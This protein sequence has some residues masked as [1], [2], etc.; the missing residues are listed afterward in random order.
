MTRAA[1]LTV[2]DRCAAGDRDDVSG[3]LLA[4]R[5]LALPASVVRQCVSDDIDRITAAVVDLSAGCDLLVTTGGT[6]LSARDV[7]PE[8]ITPLI[9]RI[10]PGM[11]EAMRSAGASTTPFAMLSRQLVGIR[12]ACLLLV[13]P[14]S[15]SGA[16][17]SLDAVWAALPHAL[18][19][20]RGAATHH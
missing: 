10:V 16:A 17:E 9:D 12:G 5:L 20:I 6:G 14:G 8:A 13:L 19:L 1:V 2:S 7:T 15:P 4:A 18:A 11:A 3:D